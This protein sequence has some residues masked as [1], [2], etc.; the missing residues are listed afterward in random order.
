VA[1]HKPIITADDEDSLAERFARR[2]LRETL[3]LYQ[4]EDRAQIRAMV[5]ERLE[6]ER[7]R[8]QAQ[9]SALARYADIYGVDYQPPPPKRADQ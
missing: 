2:T 6:R 3:D 9:P 5:A 7:S 1:Y 8:Q 4:P